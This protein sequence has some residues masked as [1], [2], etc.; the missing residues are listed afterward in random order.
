MSDTLKS[1]RIRAQ[2]SPRDPHLMR[3][4]LDAPIQS[5]RATIFDGTG[6]APPLAR[7]LFAI[8]GVSKVQV[9]AETILVTRMPSSDWQA[10]KAP[11]AAA[12]RHVLNSTDQPLGD[13]SSDIPPEESDAA[14]LAAVTDLLDRQA[15]PAIAN[16]GGHISAEGVKGGTVYLRMSGGCQGCAASTATLRGGVEQMIRAAIPDVVDIIDVTDHAAGTDPYYESGSRG[17]SQKKTG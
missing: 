3:F 2:T 17:H 5:G 4:I 8:D 13:V 12:I 11:I 15:N 7:A 1:R 10:L 14:L 16:H 6:D 9:A